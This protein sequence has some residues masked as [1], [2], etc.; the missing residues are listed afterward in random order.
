MCVT[1]AHTLTL[2]HTHTHTIRNVLQ[3]TVA[4]LQA[5]VSSS[6]QLSSVLDTVLPGQQPASNQ[7]QQQAS[8]GHR[9]ED[10]P[11]PLLQTTGESCTVAWSIVR[12]VFIQIKTIEC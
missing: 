1:H 2:T 5:V 7:D 3:S 9:K 6:L 4:A 11:G 12:V 8:N 10:L